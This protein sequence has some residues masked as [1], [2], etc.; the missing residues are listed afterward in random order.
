RPSRAAQVPSVLDRSAHAL[1]VSVSLLVGARVDLESRLVG[2]TMRRQAT[3]LLLLALACAGDSLLGQVPLLPA[4][5]LV[6]VIDN[7]SSMS[8]H[9]PQGL[10]GV[11]GSLILDSA[12]LGSDLR[13]GLVYFS[14]SVDQR[15]SLATP[16]EVR[17]QLRPGRL[18]D[19][20]GGTN[21]EG[22][23]QAAIGLL[24]GSAAP[25]KRIVLITDGQPNPGQ[26]PVILSSLVNQAARSGI[27]I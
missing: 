8:G 21:L 9:D 7:S 5:N 15:C 17:E 16:A 6:L 25:I 13:A 10:R 22:G 20:D 4:Q 19:P 3:L 11:A 24:S 1:P 2:G 26:G 14:D 27:Q 23:L 18:P 12:E